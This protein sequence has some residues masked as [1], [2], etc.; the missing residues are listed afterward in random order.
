VEHYHYKIPGW[1]SFPMLYSNMVD[2]ATNGAHFVEIGSWM[3]CSASYMGVEIA[4]SGKN[5]KFDCVDEWSDYAKGGLF[6]K[7][8]PEKP[9]DF[10]HNLFLENTAPVKQYINTVKSPSV[11]AANLYS[12][13][14][15][16]FVFIDANHVFDAVYMDISAWYPKVKIGGFIGGHDFKDEPVKRAV[17]TFIGNNN[18]IFDIRENCWLHKKII[19]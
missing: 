8:M 18:Y 13:N 12:D 16:D 10:V 15:L 6:L 2:L 1:F 4:N 11:E 9:G 14:S 17:D 3:G 7:N 5:I 19:N